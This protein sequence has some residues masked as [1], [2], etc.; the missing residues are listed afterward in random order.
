MAI[1]IPDT[2]KKALKQLASFD[3]GSTDKLY[4]A[5]RDT[6][7]R[8]GMHGLPKQI[9][10]KVGLPVAEVQGLVNVLFSLYTVRYEE[11]LST[12][13]L[14][15]DLREAIEKT[16]DANL[17]PRDSWDVFAAHLQKLLSL[18]NSF[19]IAVKSLNVLYDYPRHF[20]SVRILTDAR[21]VFASDP[22]QSPRV[23]LV[24]HVLKFAIHEDGDEKEWFLA[25]NSKD[26]EKLRQVIDRAMSKEK[27][28]AATLKTDSTTVLEWEK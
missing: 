24:N 13:S 17:T 27:S 18:E 12:E 23:F 2:S 9:A 22:T 4:A 7:P 14:I 21:P 1:K 26:L 5:L 16:G 11:G 20:H 25:L 15:G 19:G 28:L 8:L 6:P 10:E 3:D